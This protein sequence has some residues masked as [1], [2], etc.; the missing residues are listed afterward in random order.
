MTK[1]A[2]LCSIIYLSGFYANVVHAGIYP[3]TLR[4]P[5]TFYDFHSDGSNPDFNNNTATNG[6]RRYH[7]LDSFLDPEK[8]P[9]LGPEPYFNCFL[10]KWFRPW[11]PGDSSI[12]VYGNDG[13]CNGTAKIACDTAFKN[14]VLRDT[15][16]FL[17]APGTQGIYQYVNPQFYPLDGRGFGSEGNSHNYSFSME[18]HWFFT[19]IPGM[20]FHCSGGGDLWTF[21]NK[22]CAAD[23]GGIHP[24][25]S[26]SV[27]VDDIRGLKR[28]CNYGMDVFYCNR[29][30]SQS[31]IRMTVGILSSC[32]CAVQMVTS[33]DSACIN[34]GD[35]V[36]LY[37]VI[38]DD[39]GGILPEYNQYFS[40]S[41]IGDSLAGHL[42]N[43]NGAPNIFYGNQTAASHTPIRIVV[44][45]NDS[46]GEALYL[47]NRYDTIDIVITPKTA[48]LDDE[49]TRT[50][51]LVSSRNTDNNCIMYAV[52][53]RRVLSIENGILPKGISGF[54]LK[55]L[56]SG[57]YLIVD[58][59]KKKNAIKKLIP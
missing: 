45:F 38:Q 18:A 37:A 41:L 50:G 17:L 46:F 54:R 3:D 8:K 5:V 49:N 16:S 28:G 6:V 23:I 34:A 42:K 57:V 35:S 19:S 12:P 26:D 20:K 52:D 31:S 53:G 30:L 32:P 22:Q 1:I 51:P 55:G 25:I 15:L 58:K 21:V 48:V 24:A 33:P 13:T 2:F 10:K 29:Q 43:A 59:Y 40:W 39:S 14:V 11:T 4:V 44:H 56:K 9:M 7:M 47:Y 36:S 27:V